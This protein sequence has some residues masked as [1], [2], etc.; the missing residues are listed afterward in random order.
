MMRFPDLKFKIIHIK[1]DV[2]IPCLLLGSDTAFI[3]NALPSPSG[4]LPHDTSICSYATL[5]INAKPGLGNY[6]WSNN[7]IT[8]SITIDKP[9]AYWLQATDDN[10]CVGKEFVTV[11]L[12]DCT[13]G[14]YT[15]NAFTPNNDGKNDV[16]KPMIFGNVVHYSFV[17]YNRF[18][19]K[20]FES[21]DS[22]RGW[23]GRFRS[24]NSPA[25][26]FVWICSYQFAGEKIENKKGTVMLV[27]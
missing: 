12:K 21:T 22:S 15:P 27:R 5:V 20:V 9:G 3:T 26:T 4:F 23:D 11:S 16:F 25:D 19:Q 17:V 1:S 6:S 14:F 24:M 18:G 7:A 10:G 13:Q 8:S 2:G